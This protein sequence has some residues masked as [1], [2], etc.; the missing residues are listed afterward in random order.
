MLERELEEPEPKLE[1]E[2]EPG[3]E[4]ELEQP[5]GD[6]QLQKTAAYESLHLSLPR[7]RKGGSFLNP[8][9]RVALPAPTPP[10]PNTINP[11]L[12]SPQYFVI[13]NIFMCVCMYVYNQR[14]TFRAGSWLPPYGVS[15]IEFKKSS[16][17]ANTLTP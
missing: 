8:V 11:S 17:A 13:F 14:A 12:V 3:R 7:T 16:L 5:P 6:P 4:P 9:H 2:P 10:R 15:G 1:R